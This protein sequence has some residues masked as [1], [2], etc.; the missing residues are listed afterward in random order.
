M[1]IEVEPN[2]NCA[3]E[4]GLVRRELG[5]PRRVRALK[6]EQNGRE[7]VCDLT[8]V[9]RGGRWVPAYAVKVNDSGDGAAFLIYGGEWGI[10][11]GPEGCSPHWDLKNRAQW[12]E[13][14]KIYGSEED[15]LYA[16]A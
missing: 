12:G 7:T 4:E 9:A 6:T 15:I 5:K 10:R 11:L 13:P 8:G 2:P 14:Y 1:Q 16:D 3:P